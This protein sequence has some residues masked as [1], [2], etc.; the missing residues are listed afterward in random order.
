MGK[1]ITD[2]REAVSKMQE[3]QW[4]HGLHGGKPIIPNKPLVQLADKSTCTNA[5]FFDQLRVGAEEQTIPIGVER[6]DHP[7]NHPSHWD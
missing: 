4:F 3:V 7:H 6:S 2:L 5:Q 1:S